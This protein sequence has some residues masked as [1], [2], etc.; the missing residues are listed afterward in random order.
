VPVRCHEGLVLLR[1]AEIDL[2]AGYE[3]GAAVIIKSL[4]LQ[5][6]ILDAAAVIRWSRRF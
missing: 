3:P 6:I 1:K 4:V 5:S 2:E